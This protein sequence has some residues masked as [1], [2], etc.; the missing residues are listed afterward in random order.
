MF[1]DGMLG[2]NA[3]GWLVWLIYNGLLWNIFVDKTI[4]LENHIQTFTQSSSVSEKPGS[5]SA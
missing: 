3:L 5:L 1:S 2:R 4:N